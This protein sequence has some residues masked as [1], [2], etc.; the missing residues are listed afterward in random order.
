MTWDLNTV[1]L[2]AVQL[3][4]DLVCSASHP[5]HSTADLVVVWQLFNWTWSQ[6]KLI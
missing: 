2:Y 6:K 5:K 1:C 3:M 4:S